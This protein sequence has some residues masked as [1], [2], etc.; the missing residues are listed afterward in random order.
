MLR[1]LARV[2]GAVFVI[3][4]IAV[5]V[6]LV[7]SQHRMVE[8]LQTGL[9]DTLHTL[10]EA[11]QELSSVQSELKS[12]RLGVD[13]LDSKLEL[14]KDTW[15]SVVDVGNQLTAGLVNNPMATNP[16]WAQLLDFLLEDKT[17][18]NA[19]VPYEYVCSDFARDV[20]NNAEQAGIRAALVG[21]QLSNG[22]HALNAF[23][24]T[25][26]GLVF[27]DCTGPPGTSPTPRNHDKIADVWLGRDYVYSRLFPELGGAVS[28]SLGT[29]VD[30]TIYW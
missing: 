21:I 18:E 2:L 25:D 12:A 29:V 15:G 23:K 6:F 14:Y 9:T 8:S 7:Y 4:A 24:T 20:H 3:L 13:S 26:R 1:S 11:R 28:G 22:G 19:Y 27:I 30:L 5:G 10:A 16:T 17:D